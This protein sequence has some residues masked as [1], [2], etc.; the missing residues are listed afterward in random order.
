M[1]FQFLAPYRSLAVGAFSLLFLVGC[2]HQKNIT[3]TESQAKA[4][5]NIGY[6]N[7][8]FSSANGSNVSPSESTLDG[9]VKTFELLYYGADQTLNVNVET[10]QNKGVYQLHIPVYPNVKLLSL[11][12]SVETPSGGDLL[13]LSSARGACLKVNGRP[14]RVRLY[15][16]Y[17]SSVATM[18]PW[19]TGDTCIQYEWIS[20][21]HY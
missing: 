19:I 3:L 12:T 10:R 7:F 11:S 9:K 5:N 1:R 2:E 20:G 4:M 15:S 21:G 18:T 8:V 14:V 6:L 17:F 13:F 16:N